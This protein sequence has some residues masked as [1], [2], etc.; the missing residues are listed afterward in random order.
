M[1]LQE[2]NFAGS[3]I[4]VNNKRKHANHE[5]RSQSL[6]HQ[7]AP[8]DHSSR[9]NVDSALALAVENWNEETTTTT[10]SLNPNHPATLKITDFCISE[11]LRCLFV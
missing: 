4:Q 6:D 5:P 1:P 11:K 2:R 9:R 10:E 7:S 3:R 8:G